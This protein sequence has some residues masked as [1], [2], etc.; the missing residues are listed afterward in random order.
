MR[1]VPLWRCADLRALDE[2]AL[3]DLPWLME[4]AGAGLADE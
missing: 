1:E 2:R 3:Q 4:V